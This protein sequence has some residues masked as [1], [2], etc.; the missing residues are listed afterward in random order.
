VKKITALIPCY[1]EAD[2]IT[3][4]I[5]A[6]PRQ[7]LRKAGYELDILVVDNN[8]KDNTAELARASGARVITEL[9]QGKGHAVKTGFYNIA[10]DT[11]FIV[12]LDG[13]NTYRPEE[14]LRLIEPLDSGFAKV[15]IGSRMHGKIEAGSMRSLNH[16]GNRIYSRMVRTLYGVLVSD[17]LTGYFAWSREV[18]EALRPHI[19]SAGFT[20]EMEMVTK[21]A[22]LGYEIYS[23]PV[24]YYNR[25][26]DSSL[27]PLKDGALILHECLRNLR[28]NSARKQVRHRNLMLGTEMPIVS[29]FGEA[30]NN[31]KS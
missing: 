28:W 30:R 7:R 21:T 25:M 23:V 4:L 18:V 29:F 17:T 27:N 16:F 8:S 19:H 9:K 13:D 3:D 24:S 6:F 1:N 2:A 14:I 5:A 31:E 11:D 26:G 15:I 20:I 22:R 12:M 10:D